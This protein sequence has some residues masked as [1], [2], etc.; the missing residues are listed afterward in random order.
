MIHCVINSDV[1]WNPPSCSENKEKKT[2]NG[3]P[4]I[5]DTETSKSFCSANFDIICQNLRR[6]KTLDLMLR[7][8]NTVVENYTHRINYWN[9]K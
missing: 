8:K 9:K 5:V 2:N 6:F 4:L 3:I 7:K 1:F